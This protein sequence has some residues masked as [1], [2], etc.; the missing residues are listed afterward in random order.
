MTRSFASQREGCLCTANVLLLH[1]FDCMVIII[2]HST[3]LRALQTAAGLGRSFPILQVP[4]LDELK[5]GV[6][7][8]LTHA[9]VRLYHYY[10][11]HDSHA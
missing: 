2:R 4:M 11:I 10:A 8:S 7:D 9:E 5:F 3:R 1:C 6:A